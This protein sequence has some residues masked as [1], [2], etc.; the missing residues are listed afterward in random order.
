MAL[1]PVAGGQNVPTERAERR[2]AAIFAADVAGYSRLMGADEGDTLRQL[3]A[4]RRTLVDPKIAQHRGRI[5]KTT[6]D[7]MLVE[8][9]SVVDAVRCAAEVQRG[10][11]ER[12]VNVP[13]DKRIEFR[14]GINVGDI[15][16]E[17]GDIFGDGVNV[18]ARLE[19]LADPGGICVSG[20]VQE[21]TLG[22]LPL[23]FEDRGEQHVKNIV[24][25]IRVY[26]LGPKTLA[27]LPS[28]LGGI[29]KEEGG[30]SEEP[31]RSELPG[32]RGGRWPVAVLILVALAGLGA[33]QATELISMATGK[34]STKDIAPSSAPAVAVL[35]FDNLTGDQGQ[36]YFADGVSEELITVLSQVEP[37]RVLARNTTFAYRGKALDISEIGRKLRAQYVVEG[38]FRRVADTIS[39]SAQLI[40][41]GTGN[42]VWAQAY[43]RA[44]GS[45][46]LL[47]IQN[48]VARRIG[49]AIGDPQSGAI[50]RIEL[51][52][53]RSKAPS[54]LSSYECLLQGYQALAAPS[55][56]E[57]SRR[58]RLCLET[59][60]GREPQNALAWSMLAR[61]LAFQRQWGIG[62][63]GPEA[64][65][66][67]KR[68]Y[69]VSRTAEAANRGVDLAPASALAHYAMFMSYRL[70]CQ[71]DRMRVEAERVLA[72]NP[73]DAALLGVLGNNLA[74]AG[75]W[76]LGVQ[77]A[78]K[79]LSL[80]GPSAPRWWWWAAAANHY[81]K[82]QY[83]EALEY[84]RRSYVEHNWLDHLQLAYTL[85]YVGKIEEAR[86]E[87]PILM[88]LK[89][90]ISI[91]EA[92]RY[93]TM[94]CFDKDFRE[95]MATALRLAGLRENGEQAGKN[96]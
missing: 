33:W 58:A 38:S 91:Q 96:E 88:R 93:F 65:D 16:T 47:A 49:A 80:A 32:V 25:P 90:S 43:E 72:I 84:F 1:S 46:S 55:A 39:V 6:G 8:F 7:G 3:K 37:L 52:R 66:I 78:E 2:L 23:S 95:K 71:P 12:N 44:V 69:L 76:D 82:G 57:P 34:H 5:V 83:E 40:D 63:D 14:I 62:L 10:M 75:V 48:E 24:R 61:V 64:D 28:S 4:H 79:G 67:D 59:T 35:S 81:R 31:R 87:I 45:T 41:A 54:E 17:G 15:I 30:Y 42:H 56:P 9:A 50:A 36:D 68:A 92:D 22:R 19:T 51:E 77:L 11:A 89:P 86:A 13:E 74:Y 27:E 29:S 60:A 70:T 85:P 21:D 18:A 26:A 20:R 53:S 73:N 94:W